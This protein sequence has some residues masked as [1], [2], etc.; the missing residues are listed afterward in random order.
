MKREV[1]KQRD[2]EKKRSYHYQAWAL[3]QIKAFDAGYE[4]VKQK[5]ISEQKQVATDSFLRDIFLGGIAVFPMTAWD[6][7]QILSIKPEYKTIAADMTQCL[8]PISPVYLD[9][10]VSKL[11]AESFEKGWDKLGEKGGMSLRTLVAQQEAIVSKK[12][13]SDPEFAT[14]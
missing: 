5:K 4:L 2:S 13:P 9:T 3:E 11:Y 7:T 10:A 1:D 8:L 14:K 12:T 6:I